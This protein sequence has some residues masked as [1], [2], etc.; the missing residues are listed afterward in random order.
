LAVYVAGVGDPGPASLRGGLDYALSRALKLDLTAALASAVPAISRRWALNNPQADTVVRDLPA[1][2]AS[3]LIQDGLQAVKSGADGGPALDAL[4]ERASK[5]P[6]PK[7]RA[8]LQA[9]AAILA[10]LGGGMSGASRALFAGFAIANPAAPAP[11]LL[12]LDLA[13]SAGAT[14]ETALLVLS[15]AQGGGEAGPAPAD[16]AWIIRALVRTGL[17]ADAR[18]FAIEGLAQLRGPP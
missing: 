1:G 12:T 4:V 10:S 9:A 13:S 18:A 16:R 11:R 17:A 6:G 5:E 15:V 2:S 14:G 7:T 8:R 3:A